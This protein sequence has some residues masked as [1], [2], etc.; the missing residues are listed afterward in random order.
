M[1]KEDGSEL[2]DDESYGGDEYERNMKVLLGGYKRLCKAK[3]EQEEKLVSMDSLLRS[4]VATL[5][6]MEICE[7]KLVEQ[8]ETGGFKSVTASLLRRIEMSVFDGSGPYEWFSKVERFFRVDALNKHP[9]RISNEKERAV[10]TLTL[11]GPNKRLLDEVETLLDAKHDSPRIH[12][13]KD[14]NQRGSSGSGSTDG[15]D[16]RG[17]SGSGSIDR[18]DQRGSSGNG[19]TD[20]LDQRSSEGNRLFAIRQH[21]FVAAYV[22][23]FEDLS[24]Q[25]PGLDNSH[26]EKSFY[27][28]LKQEMRE[29]SKM[30]EPRGLP[31]QKAV[32]LRME[33]SSFCQMIGERNGKVAP[34]P[35]HYTRR[36][37]VPH[38]QQRQVM[39]QGVAEQ[40]AP[41]V[42]QGRQFLP[43]RQHHTAEELDAVRRLPP[44]RGQE[45]SITLLPGVTTI[46][47]RPYRYPHS[48]KEVIEKMVAEMLTTGIIPL[49]R[50]T[51]PDKFLIPVIDQ[52]LDE[53]HG[54]V[55]F[56][57]ID[58]RYGYHQILLKEEDIQKTAF[59]T[60]EGN[61]EFLV[62]P[63]GLT[64]APATFQALMNNVFKLYLRRF[65]VVFFDDILV[66]SASLDEHVLH[67]RLVLQLLLD[68]QLYA[69]MK[70]SLFGE[71]LVEYLG[72][73][74]SAE[75]V[76]TDKAKTESM[77]N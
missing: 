3:A 40:I 67:L 37:V 57:K 29:V 70:K 27:N 25:V 64:N 66:Y 28:G 22:T 45:H 52:L 30:K 48:T 12:L 54:A 73:I 2:Y 41:P 60:L 75:G 50:A 63:F 31:N 34:P 46:T 65:V 8:P 5:E 36:A 10:G 53:L 77:I 56:S 4:V 43:T 19:S 62:M 18:L 55:I 26:L 20:R 9:K 16:Q 11:S 59:R 21:G 24:A 38:N 72:H 33:S 44:V 23:K 15:L 47:V 35:R 69:N 13:R 17:S 58:L 76:A 74:I 14:S 61:Y 6:R 32:V 68:H 51:I 7:G 49:K 1:V 42:A 71:S 39:L